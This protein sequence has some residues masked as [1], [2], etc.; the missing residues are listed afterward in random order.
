M[1]D[2]I[3]FK[4]SPLSNVQIHIFTELYENEDFFEKLLSLISNT[5]NDSNKNPNNLIIYFTFEITPKYEILSFST[6]IK[7]ITKTSLISLFTAKFRQKFYSIVIASRN[8]NA[9]VNEIKIIFE[10]MKRIKKHVYLIAL[11]FADENLINV[12]HSTINADIIVVK[13]YEHATLKKLNDF[14]SERIVETKRLHRTIMF[15]KPQYHH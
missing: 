13:Y 5:I 1:I 6:E 12:Y 11:N 8:I 3:F 15:S 7:N 2:L 9:N 10:K 4:I 14:K